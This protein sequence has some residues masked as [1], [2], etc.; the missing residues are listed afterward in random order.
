MID[1]VFLLNGET[2]VGDAGRV[3]IIGVFDFGVGRG[4]E[5]VNVAVAIS[6]FLV[7]GPSFRTFWRAMVQLSWVT[8]GRIGR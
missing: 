1:M 6:Y 4:E 7:R 3:V 2:T 8:Q 5:V